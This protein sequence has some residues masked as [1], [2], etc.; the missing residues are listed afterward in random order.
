M[1]A[2]RLR[3]RRGRKT[4]DSFST[5][6]G[7]AVVHGNAAYFS[8]ENKVYLY[9]IAKDEWTKLKPREYIIQFGLAVVN[10]KITTIGGY[11]NGATNSLFSL[12]GGL[13]GVTVG[14]KWKDLLPPMHTARVRPASITTHTH[15]IVAGGLLHGDVVEVLDIR[16]LLWSS[17]S[18]SPIPLEYPHMTCC[19]GILYLSEHSIIFSC[20]LDE[21]LEACKPASTKFNSSGDGGST[22]HRLADIPSPGYNSS[23]TSVRGHVLAIGGS[24]RNGSNLT[25]DVYCYSRSTNSWSVIGEMPT[26]R[27]ETLVVVTHRNELIAVGGSNGMGESYDITEIA[28]TD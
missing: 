11:R 8:Q 20:S 4:P 6:W 14:T 28:S 9:V 25:G 23:L 12:T 3:W 7:A 22:W 2:V 13:F 21:L 27:C 18:S 16:T 5:L 15:L 26:R 10:D 24:G 1:D 19:G 17:A